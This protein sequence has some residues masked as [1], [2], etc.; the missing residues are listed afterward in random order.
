MDRLEAMQMLVTV[1]EQGSFSAASRALNVPLATLSRKV[2]D[3]ETHLGIRLLIRTTRK[4]S[5]TDAGA[6]YVRAARRILEQVDE[7]ERDATGE[8]TVPKG[9]LVITAPIQFG[10]LHVLPVV[11]DFLAE[12]PEINVRLHLGDRNVDLIDDQ[13]DMAVRIG[14]LP[15]SSMVATAIGDMRTVTCAS[16]ALL[17]R[18]AVPRHPR[19][20]LGLPCVMVDT[21]L[22]WPAW[23]YRDPQ[24]RTPLDVPI[25]PRLAVTTTE[26]AA[27][28]ARQGVGVTRLLHYQVADAVQNGTLRIVLEAFEPEPAP[29][30]LI[31]AARGRMPLKM[32]RFLDLATPQLRAAVRRVA[33]SDPPA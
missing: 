11:S 7:A 27:Q 14:A 33:H 26:A 13:V 12:F 5:L 24:Q 20:L 2:A 29:V 1:T 18:F 30:H 25:L 10:R 28:A 9:E 31:H 6:G 22:P 3:L 32:R 17:G 21:P 8:F 23:R 4:L 16:P 19:E 15:D